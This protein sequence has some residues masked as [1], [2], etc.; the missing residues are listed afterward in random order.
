MK[1][2]IDAR[3]IFPEIS[4]IGAYT[5]ELIRHLAKIDTVNSYILFFDNPQVRDRTISETNL[6]NSRNF[7]T[8]LLPFGAFSIK[9]QILLPGI[10]ANS[11][12]D[13]YHSTNY[14]IPFFAFPRK[15]RGKVKCVVTIHDVIPMIFPGHAPKSKKARFFPIYKRLMIEVGIH[16]NAIITD[17]E[18][19]RND[20]IKYL[21]IP[22]N[23]QT[24]IKAIHCGVSQQFRPPPGG[25][26]ID[27]P[28]PLPNRRKRTILYVGRSDPYKN[29]STLIM[30]FFSAI[31]VCPFPIELVIA[32]PIDPRYPEAAI[33]TSKLGIENFVKWTGYLSDEQLVETYQNADLLVQPSKYEGFGL[34]VV[35][36][37]ACGVPVICS[38]AGS[39]PEV[40]GDAAILLDPEDI[41]GF[42][43]K[44]H[45]VLTDR[46]TIHNMSAKGIE[47]AGKFS[48]A[49]TAR[50]TFSIYEEMVRV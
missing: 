46:T 34:Q 1:I 37:M 11:G 4:G 17:S 18:A 9:N 38:N 22:E 21:R 36:A 41:N 25:H 39:L 47:Q 12:F 43:D 45:E 32:G 42:T 19:S 27:E 26:K 14:M 28:S 29:L 13:I 48:W 31:K 15:T 6:S 2:A 23:S 30:A 35:E 16:A 40:T 10:L 20:V 33:L 3:W 7:S 44:I 5:R 49:R 50:E 24:I 8:H